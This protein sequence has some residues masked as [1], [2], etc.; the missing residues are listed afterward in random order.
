MNQDEFHE[1]KAS[2]FAAF[3]STAAWLAALPDPAA[4][5]AMWF[6][7]LE[8]SS[9]EDADR[10][11]LDMN[12]GALEPP[13]FPSDTA[14]VVARHIR[15]MR[16]RPAST[17][18]SAPF[19][20]EGEFSAAPAFKEMVRSVKGGMN[21]GEAVSAM[22]A[23]LPAT[24]PERERRVRCLECLDTGIVECWSVR[25]MHAA[26][27][28]YFGRPNTMT[29]AVVACR[30]HAGDKYAAQKVRGTHQP[31]WQTYDPD[32]WLPCRKS[33]LYFMGPLRQERIDKLHE[34]MRGF[35]VR[36]FNPGGYQVAF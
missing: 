16:Y 19:V 7:A 29:T 5:L 15:E 26:A 34:F 10:V 4:T 9:L 30:C 12:N 36:E 1:W 13:A 20:P 14:R 33:D 8:F 28:G 2:Y 22:L 31:Y 25:A 23:S 3:P 6:R 27:H 21:F 24:D 18:D 35:G 11:A 17:G 32:K